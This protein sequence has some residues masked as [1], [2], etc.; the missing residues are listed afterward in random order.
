MKM[1]NLSRIYLV[2]HRQ[3]LYTDS[4]KYKYSCRVV[5]TSPLGDTAVEPFEA[6]LYANNES[7]A[8]EISSQLAITVFG[9]DP[10][11]GVSVQDETLEEI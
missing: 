8:R 1:P 11:I 5:V 4:M 9:V 3:I 2:F 7:E 10:D 6:I